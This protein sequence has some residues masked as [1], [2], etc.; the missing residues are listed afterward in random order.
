MDKL[1]VLNTV[2][3]F[4]AFRKG[5]EPV[6]DEVLNP[7]QFGVLAIMPTGGGKSLLYQ[8]PALLLDGITIVISPLISLMKDQVMALQ[9]KGVKAA[10]YN[11][12][13]TEDEKRNIVAD[14]VSDNIKILYVAP[15][16]FEDLTFT[17][18]LTSKDIALIAIDEAHC[19]SSWGHAFRPSYRKIGKFLRNVKPRQVMALT[20]TATPKVQD[21]ICVQLGLNSPKVF[22]NGF[23]RGDLACT[24]IECQDTFDRILEEVEE[25]IEAGHKT[26]LI[27]CST[28][29]LVYA[30][31]HTL[32]ENDIPCEM[33]HAE[34]EDAERSRVQENWIKNGGIIVATNALGMGIDRPDVRFVYHANMPGTVEA[35]YQEWGR[36][37]RDGAGGECIMFT[38]IK[39]DIRLQHFFIDIQFPPSDQV[40]MFYDWLL[41]YAA[42][43]GNAFGSALINLT[44]EKMAE[45]S[46]IKPEYASGCVSFL[47][48]F[49]A[50]E[51]VG[52]GKYEVKMDRNEDIRWDLLDKKRNDLIARLNETIK[53]TKNTKNCRMMEFV[54]YFGD[55][56]MSKGCGKCDVCLWNSKKKK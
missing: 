8:L 37:S 50:I 10:F 4:S 42:D 16:R 3:G 21:D 9:S 26:G 34:L 47:K 51:T 52:R 7:T 44:Q 53:F 56:T 5:Q 36:A 12:S 45:R 14:L 55:Y 31:Y 17:D 6:I 22:I 29:K 43:K 39:A 32:K 11:S 13:L 1:T 41:K 19:I 33:Y 38:N 27:Y 40:Q 18:I 25:Q 15:E 48:K 46:G 54:N 24:I 35:L 30:L 49:N 23:F 28:R 2:F 20:A